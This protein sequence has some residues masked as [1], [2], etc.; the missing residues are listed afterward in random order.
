[1]SKIVDYYFSPMSPWTYL[2]HVRFARMLARLGAQVNVKPVDYG[3]IF[4]VSGGLP[5]RQRAVQRQTYRLTELRR[6]REHLGVQLNLEPKYFPYTTDAASLMIIAADRRRGAEAAMQ[7]AY[8][9]MQ[10]CWAEERDCADFATLGQVAAAAGL[11][12]AELREAQDDAKVAYDAYTREA[13]E[14]QVFGAPSY[15]VGGEIFWGQDRLDFLERRL[16][17]S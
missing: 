9:I 8:G 7:L 17:R 4:P 16:A 15:V 6:W 10:A 11:D 2:G 13:V 5:V 14:R 12:A 3:R 1:M